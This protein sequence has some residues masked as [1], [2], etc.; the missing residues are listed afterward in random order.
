MLMRVGVGLCRHWSSIV[1]DVATRDD[2]RS[3][4]FDRGRTFVDA[5][6]ERQRRV[7]DHIIT[8]AR[9]PFQC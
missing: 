1:L 9:I 6:D 5:C 3:R 7:S 8:G 4:T 2:F